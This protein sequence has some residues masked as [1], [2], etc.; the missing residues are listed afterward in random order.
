MF[1]TELRYVDKQSEYA[2]NDYDV[3]SIYSTDVWRL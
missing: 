2:L 3:Y 1:S